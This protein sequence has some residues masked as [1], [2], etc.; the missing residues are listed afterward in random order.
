MAT[1][2]EATAFKFHK[3]IIDLRVL[4]YS[5]PS[6]LLRLK[7]AVSRACFWLAR[8]PL[9]HGIN[10]TS[11]LI[12]AKLRDLQHQADLLRKV[13]GGSDMDLV[14]RSAYSMAFVRFVNGFLDPFQQ[15]TFATALVEIA[16]KIQ[17]PYAF[18][19]LRHSATHNQL[20]T[21]DLLRD[22]TEQALLWLWDHY[23]AKIEQGTSL[24]R[25]IESTPV[26][27][28]PELSS[29]RIYEMLKEYR[30]QHKKIVGADG[31]KIQEV[32]QL[33]KIV[34]NPVNAS[35]LAAL[36]V[37]HWEKFGAFRSAFELY[38][39]LIQS[40]PSPFLYQ[41]VVIL[42]ASEAEATA[43]C[44]FEGLVEWV[45]FLLQTLRKGEFPFRYCYLFEDPSD[46]DKAFDSQLRLLPASHA[47][48]KLQDGSN[49]RKVFSKPAL[50]DE[51]LQEA[52]PPAKEPKDEE[53][54]QK[55]RKNTTSVLETFEYWSPVPFGVVPK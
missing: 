8:E 23:W 27:E 28:N 32:R 11:M 53:I 6:D 29:R 41:I 4:F 42:I 17:L 47:L 30:T 40:L 31:A 16:K 20:P 34:E 7:E 36:L 21:L 2:P 1:V 10:S 37:K 49:G 5:D 51:I 24:E 39:P 9:P 54:R 55:K 48:R 50:L 52:T 15:G 43:G 13:P 12:S 45:A 18:V 35:K 14:L 33:R 3:D 46:V 38:K 19:E 22:M 26:R 25:S 44:K